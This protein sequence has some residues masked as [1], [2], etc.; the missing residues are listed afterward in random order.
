MPHNLLHVEVIHRAPSPADGRSWGR[1]VHLATQGRGPTE[2]ISKA[3]EPTVAAVMERQNPPVQNATAEDPLH[4]HN[5]AHLLV[6]GVPRQR[7]S[8]RTDPAGD[9]SGPHPTP[10]CPSCGQRR[11]RQVTTILRGSTG[12]EGTGRETV[13][14]Q[15]PASDLRNFQTTSSIMDAR[16]A[17]AVRAAASTGPTNSYSTLLNWAPCCHGNPC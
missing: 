5:T 14:C 9:S 1:G 3:G 13:C 17:S 4:Q 16:E 8:S 2:A 7:C 6:P 11:K 10:Q 15:I 12:E